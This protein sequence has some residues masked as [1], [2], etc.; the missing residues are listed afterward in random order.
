M[1]LIG[2]SWNPATVLALA[3]IFGLPHRRVGI[4]CEHLDRTE[5]KVD[6]IFRPSE[7][8]TASS[9]SPTLSAKARMPWLTPS[10]ITFRTRITSPRPMHF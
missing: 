9:Y 8:F 6:G 3:A 4:E 2:G 5:A 10:N 7:S 1:R